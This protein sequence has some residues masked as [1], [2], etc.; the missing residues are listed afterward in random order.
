MWRRISSCWADAARSEQQG[1]GIPFLFHKDRVTVIHH[2]SFKFTFHLKF[3]KINS[4]WDGGRGQRRESQT[5]WQDQGTQ[6]SQNRKVRS[7]V[8]Q[9]F[10]VSYLLTYLV[11][12][13]RPNFV[14]KGKLQRDRRK[15]RE[16]RRSTGV[17]HLQSTEVI[18][19]LGCHLLFFLKTR[20]IFF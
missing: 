4:W 6:S 18:D 9:H 12:S 13:C 2:P 5:S 19:P 17:V 15:L 11:C 7:T 16:K 10:P 20:F 1:P 3:F 14:N 8:I